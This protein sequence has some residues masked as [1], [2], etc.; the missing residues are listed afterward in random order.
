MQERI[1]KAR[2]CFHVFPGE[3]EFGFVIAHILIGAVTGE[4]VR[5]GRAAGGGFETGGAGDEIVRGNAAVTP[6]ADAEAIGI[7]QAARDRVVHRGEIVLDIDTSPSGENAH[8]EFFAAP[9]RA[10][11]VRHDDGVTVGGEELLLEVERV[12]VLRLRAA[13]RAQERGRFRAGGRIDRVNDEAVNFGA[14][15]A[16]EFRFFDA[17]E[18]DR[19]EPGVVLF[20]QI[21]QIVF[22]AA[23]I[24]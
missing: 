15:F 13:V 21:A 1:G 9:S 6:T 22:S 24:S 7:G 19:R 12:G 17:S 18:F 8:G 2:P 3:A 5:D 16:F 14:V 20:R 10:A 11:R 4:D 23:K